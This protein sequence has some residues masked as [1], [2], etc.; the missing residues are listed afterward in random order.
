[1]LM[2]SGLDGA[3]NPPEWGDTSAPAADA[4]AATVL[5]MLVAAVVVPLMWAS[6]RDGLRGRRRRG[7]R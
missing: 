2:F 1:M 5:F 3:S 6:I 7:R 4:I